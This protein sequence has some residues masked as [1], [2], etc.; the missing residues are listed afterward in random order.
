MQNL[1]PDRQKW[2][3]LLPICWLGLLLTALLGSAC[4]Q[5]AAPARQLAPPTVTT[6]EPAPTSP[7]VSGL[8]RAEVG[9]ASRQKFLDHFDKHGR[10]F[11]SLTAN[12][13][14][15]QAQTLRDRPAGKD[16]LEVV[17]ADGVITRFDKTSGAFLA[18]NSDL[19]IRTYFKPNDGVNYFWRQSRR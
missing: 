1:R 2:R 15:R 4:Q 18:F 11:G 14:L 17:R 8:V 7:A 12:E 5:V 19:T 10:E 16:V 3:M 6:P 13:Y 9:F